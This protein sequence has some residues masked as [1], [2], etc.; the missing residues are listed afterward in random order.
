MLH[1]E[2]S[3]GRTDQE[4]FL[5]SVVTAYIF[6]RKRQR[7]EE[8]KCRALK[9]YLCTEPFSNLLFYAFRP[10][11]LKDTATSTRRTFPCQVEK[12]RALGIEAPAITLDIT[13]WTNVSSLDVEEAC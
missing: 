4:F 7:H 2:L 9:T 1:S 10:D 5:V 11:D 13:S 12:V 3:R 8:F 6:L